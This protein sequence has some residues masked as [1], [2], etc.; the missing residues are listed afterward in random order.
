[1]YS[2]LYFSSQVIMILASNPFF[3]TLYISNALSTKTVDTFYTEYEVT[4]N[5]LSKLERV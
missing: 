2:E 5:A 4:R 1:M 3:N